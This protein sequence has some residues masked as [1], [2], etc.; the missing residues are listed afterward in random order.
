V[1]RTLYVC[2]SPS[3]AAW[4]PLHLLGR[5]A[6]HLLS[7][8]LQQG[9]TDG[10]GTTLVPLAAKIQAP[11]LRALRLRNFEPPWTA[12]M[13][14]NITSIMLCHDEGWTRGHAPP[15]LCELLF[16]EVLDALE[17]CPLLEDFLVDIPLLFGDWEAVPRARVVR[18]P[19]LQNL[20]ITLHQHG[21]S[22]VEHLERIVPAPDV[23]IRVSDAHACSR[24]DDDLDFGIVGETAE[25]VAHMLQACAAPPPT[26]AEFSTDVPELM[27]TNDPVSVRFWWRGLDIS[28]SFAVA[29]PGRVREAFRNCLQLPMHALERVTL[30]SQKETFNTAFDKLGELW[31]V[32]A[33]LPCLHTLVLDAGA[34]VFFASAWD[35]HGARA[36]PALRVVTMARFKAPSRASSALLRVLQARADGGRRLHELRIARLSVRTPKDSKSGSAKED[37][38]AI[39]D[40]WVERILVLVEEVVLEERG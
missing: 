11:Q 26:D 35:A 25:Y 5:D 14:T 27:Q 23:C 18:L 1:L 16:V 3:S 7:M 24:R 10:M 17:R 8:S 13:F 31:P 9:T 21:P 32:L 20:Q 30:T 15:T 19:R 22:A 4:A 39:C 40:T 29:G 28:L 12:A 2:A 36:F 38:R 37:P 33:D 34:G 6:P